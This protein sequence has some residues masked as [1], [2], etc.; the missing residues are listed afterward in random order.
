MESVCL[1]MEAF[2][3]YQ[4]KFK[5]EIWGH[6]GDAHDLEFTRYDNPPANNKERLEILKTMHAHSQ[7]CMSGDHTLEATRHAIKNI[8]KEEADEYFVVVLSDAN[9][10]RYGIPPAMLAEAL[11]QDAEVNSFVIFIG[12]LGDQA[13]RLKRSLPSGRSFVCLNTSDI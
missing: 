13:D 10:Q 4:D 2:D 12:S 3:G 1:V 9:L 7:F 5:Y 8:K 6:S 11:N